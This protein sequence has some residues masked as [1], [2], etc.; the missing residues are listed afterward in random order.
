L[1][2][3]GGYI[4]YGNKPRY[5]QFFKTSHDQ[6]DVEVEADE[7]SSLVFSS[8]SDTSDDSIMGLDEL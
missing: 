7:S 1:D 8:I 3:D 5:K 4:L 6:C 2:K